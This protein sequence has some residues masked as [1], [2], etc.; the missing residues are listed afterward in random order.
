MIAFKDDVN[1]IP[2]D[3]HHITCPVIIVHGL[4]DHMVTPGNGFCAQ[5]KLT[6]SPSVKL[7]TIENGHHNI[8]WTHYSEVKDAILSIAAN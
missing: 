3:L 2:S 1:T 8:P 5:K 7:I 4:S 6:G